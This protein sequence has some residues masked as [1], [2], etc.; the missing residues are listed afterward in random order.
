M[1]NGQPG[2]PPTAA[3]VVASL[4]AAADAA[5]QA[6][7]A[8]LAA[9]PAADLSQLYKHEMSA[10]ALWSDAEDKALKNDPAVQAAQAALDAATAKVR[11]SL[12]TLKDI[13][14]WLQLL[15]GLVNLATS[16]S[17]FLA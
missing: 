15:D 6:Y 8:A 7:W 13:S 4:G 2:S 16:V 10:Y 14:Q 17:K 5:R 11:S 12:A 1:A 9:N 3:D